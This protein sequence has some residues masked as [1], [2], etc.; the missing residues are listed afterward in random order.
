MNKKEFLNK[1]DTITNRVG[2][3]KGR[4][5]ANLKAQK[6][7]LG[8]IDD[9][10][11]KIDNLNWDSKLDSVYTKYN[12]ARDFADNIVDEAN[13]T[14]EEIRTQLDFLEGALNDLGVENMPSLDEGINESDRIGR[15]IQGLIDDLNSGV[16]A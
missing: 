12:E 5:K 4:T 8:L 13:T 6:I 2:K 9:I 7:H 3:L 15:Q 11:T 1:L 16:L 14:H 10:W